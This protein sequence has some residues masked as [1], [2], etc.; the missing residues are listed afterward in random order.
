[1]GN[2]AKEHFERAFAL[3]VGDIYITF[4]EI[5]GQGSRSLYRGSCVVNIISYHSQGF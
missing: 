1:M 3:G 5:L 4:L 2:G